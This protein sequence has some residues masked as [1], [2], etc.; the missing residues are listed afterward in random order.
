[1]GRKRLPE[2]AAGSS[3]VLWLVFVLIL[4]CFLLAES[5]GS[6]Q[7]RFPR[8]IEMT[9][10]LPSLTTQT[11][12]HFIILTPSINQAAKETCGG[13]TVLHTLADEIAS[14]GHD[15]RKLDWKTLERT[16]WDCQVKHDDTVVI[17]RRAGWI[18]QISTTYH[19]SLDIGT[20]RIDH[21][22]GDHQEV[23]ARRLGVSLHAI[24]PWSSH[25]CP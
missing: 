20:F 5:T 8:T 14:L 3:G 9:Q 19:H 1:M 11:S 23:R 22:S 24:R 2:T 15:V 18:M 4:L 21:S 25:E 6:A 13:C 7:R 10:V 17:L 16:N 12:P